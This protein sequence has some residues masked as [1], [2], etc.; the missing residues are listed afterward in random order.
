MAEDPLAK[1]LKL[2]GPILTGAKRQHFLPR[3][4]LEGFTRGG[5]LAVYDRTSNETRVQQPKDTGVIGHFYTFED[6]EGRKRFELEHALSLSETQASAV[7]RKLAA[8][9]LID[10]AE[11]SELALFI[12]LGACRTPDFVDSLK[13]AKSEMIRQWSQREFSSVK[14]VSKN[15]ARMYGLPNPTE[16]TER[17]AQELVEFSQRGEYDIVV[18]GQWAVGMA[19]QLALT[20]APL[21]ADRHWDILHVENTKKSFLTADSPVLLTTMTSRP[22]GFL[23]RGVGFANADAVVVFPLTASTSLVMYGQGKRCRHKKIDTN[24]VRALNLRLAHQCQRFL[25]GRDKALINSIAAHLNLP[26]TSW[27]PKIQV[28]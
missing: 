10:D 23:Y 7:I 3:F 1:E 27:E 9:D 18:D 5:L 11:K 13:S 24:H 14:R 19:M 16:E 8:A 25:I 12:A 15:L 6:E 22:E 28:G 26:N 20:I 17:E 4:Y 2:K 21:L